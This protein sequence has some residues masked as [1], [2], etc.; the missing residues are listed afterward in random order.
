MF[1]SSVFAT[2]YIV[3]GEC[4]LFFFPVSVDSLS[5]LLA[6]CVFP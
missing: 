4:L 5:L 6:I 1:E 2:K 3:L